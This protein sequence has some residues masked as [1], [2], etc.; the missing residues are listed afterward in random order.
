MIAGFLDEKNGYPSNKFELAFYWE[1]LK[2]QGIDVVSTYTHYLTNQ[3]ILHSKASLYY[4]KIIGKFL[5][6]TLRSCAKISALSYI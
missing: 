3:G 2:E 4:C 6:F 5:L 1:T